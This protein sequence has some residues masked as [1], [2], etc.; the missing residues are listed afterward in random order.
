VAIQL[1]TV[2][3]LELSSIRDDADLREPWSSSAT[4]TVVLAV[5]AGVVGALALA[6]AD[7]AS[8]GRILGAVLVGSWGAAAVFVARHRPRERLGALMGFA[9]L[10]SA[11]A[12]FGSAL[13]ARGAA[14]DGARDWAGEVR[15]IG[16]AL[17][18]AVGVHL[19]LGLPDGVLRSALRR[20]EV[21]AAYLSS[22]VVAALLL[23]RRPEV[24]VAP[25]AVMA[26]A[27]AAVSLIGY[28]ARCRRARSAH[29]RARLQWVA[30]AVVVAGAISIVTVV[31]HA[32]VDW[33]QATG[34]IAVSTTILV[35]LA[36]ALGASERIAVR[37]D[38]LLVHTITLAGLAAMVAACYLLIVLGLGRE[39][40]GSEQRL[41]RCSGCLCASD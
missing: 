31:L 40:T 29:E 9:A 39:P 14:S 30:W 15:A 32:L 33:P 11:V 4:T 13:L 10:V 20:V 17:L 3:P 37:I 5:V 18:P 22:A 16:V 19:A 25:V 23:D 21:G 7:D 12:L 34:G 35:P 2:E 8:A 1:D 36:L 6:L 41:P 27:G 24:A 28:L 26:A 38:R